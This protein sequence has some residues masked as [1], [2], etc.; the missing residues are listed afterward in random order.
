[1]SL[2]LAPKNLAGKVI[3]LRIDINSALDEKK[4]PLDSPRFKAHS[5]LIL[6]LLKNKAKLAIIAHQGRKGKKDYL[7]SL[8]K[9]A[10]ILSKHIE[11]KIEYVDDLFG[12]KAREKIM[13]LNSGEAILLENVRNYEE[14]NLDKLKSNYKILCSLCDLYINDAFSVCH[15]NQASVVLPAGFLKSFAGL[16]LHNELEALN[17]FTARKSENVSYLLGGEKLEDY[18]PLFKVLE[19]PNA[20][21]LASGVLANAFLIAKGYNLGY[22]NIWMKEKGYSHLLPKLRKILDKHSRQII[23]PLDFVLGEINPNKT[24][25]KEEINLSEF[26]VNK[27]VWD[28]GHKTSI[29]FKEHLLMTDKV[30]MKGP[31]GFS[32]IPK[33]SCSTIEVLKYISEL[34]KEK[35]IFSLLGGGHLTTTLAEYKIPNNFSYISLSGGAALLYLTGEKLPGLE[36]LKKGGGRHTD[37]YLR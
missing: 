17:K 18:I 7:S 20:K 19:N 30:F 33:F 8:E 5:K 4:N 12:K 13:N 23:L 22:E 16:N 31:L 24:K 9:H 1:M 27:K 21:I 25:I 32:E 3:L 14:D 29:L 28:V 26:P 35:K 37:N 6:Q 15:R 10:K 34:T 11:R 2:K 36:A